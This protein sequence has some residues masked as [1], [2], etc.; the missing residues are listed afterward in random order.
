[1]NKL[2]IH[3]AKLSLEMF[4]IVFSVLLALFLDDR[5][6]NQ[7]KRQLMESVTSSLRL[8]LEL[9]QRILEFRLP[10]H[11]ARLDTF[12]ALVDGMME[13]LEEDNPGPLPPTFQIP[14]LKELNFNE[15]VGIFEP[16]SI[17]AWETA[18]ASA[19]ASRMEPGLVYVLSTAYTSQERVNSITQR[20]REKQDTYIS[21]WVEGER[22]ASALITFTSTLT[23][24]V[25]WEQ[26]LCGNYQRLARRAN[27]GEGS[28]DS[29]CGSGNLNIR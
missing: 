3:W 19:A 16:F 9:N 26:R 23:D 11:E 5:R 13:Q 8:E 7:N 18:L 29:R 2:P 14:S 15:S 24:L 28:G 4:V 6:Q 20:L 21:A 1:M 12:N 25:L 10:Y 17:A 27:W 22:P